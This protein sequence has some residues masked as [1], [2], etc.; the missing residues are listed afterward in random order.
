[1]P[2]DVPGEDIAMTYPYDRAP[3]PGQFNGYDVNNRG[4]MGTNFLAASPSDPH[5]RMM[6]QN[7][8]QRYGRERV[9]V[10]NRQNLS[11]PVMY[12]E[13]HTETTCMDVDSPDEAAA[14]AGSYGTPRSYSR[15]GCSIYG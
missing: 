12:D 5:S 9:T 6:V 13:R 11:S 3:L 2:I 7:P 10:V 14:D 1:M 8:Q 15:Q 4:T